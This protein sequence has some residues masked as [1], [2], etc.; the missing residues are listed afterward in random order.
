MNWI[1]ENK[2]LTAILVLTLA[3]AALLLYL[4][5]GARSEFAE[6]SERYQRQAAE[7]RR[8]QALKPYPD[9]ENL[10]QL[11]QQRDAFIA[12]VNSLRS[13]LAAMK[14]PMTDPSPEEF[15]DILR[16]TVSEVQEMARAQNVALPEGFYLGF[17]QYQAS[18]PRA[19]ATSRI[20]EA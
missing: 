7:L 1:R 8:L 20:R 3:G 2:F 12:E 6:T 18:P 17:P 19:E 16:A 10:D 9:Q 15:Q 14:Y 5:T 11:T 13:T 4:L